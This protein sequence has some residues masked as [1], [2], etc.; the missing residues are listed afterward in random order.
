MKY[1]NSEM[2]D[3]L[4]YLAV[5]REHLFKKDCSAFSTFDTHVR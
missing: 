3:S 1:I 5:K 4:R 2:N